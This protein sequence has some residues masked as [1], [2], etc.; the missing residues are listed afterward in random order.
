[1]NKEVLVEYDS[2]AE[3]FEQEFDEMLSDEDIISD[4]IDDVPIGVPDKISNVLNLDQLPE[5][6]DSQIISGNYKKHHI[7]LH[8]L[9]FSI[10]NPKGSVRRGITPDGKRWASELP[11]HYGYIKKTEGAD[12]DH[13]DAF[14]G[15][16]ESSELVFIVDQK[17][18]TTGEFDEHKCIFGCLSMAQALEL[19]CQAF[20]DGK[21]AERVGFL[22][23]LHVSQFKDWLST[24]DIT[25]PYKE[26]AK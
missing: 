25:R 9:D 26:E 16:E 7:K 10:E 8:G 24:G 12:G 21:G 14:I 11:A 15:P 3:D 23:P 4:L 1:M 18:H 22:S 13:V 5:P 20:S 6:T 2:D 19:Y 17:D